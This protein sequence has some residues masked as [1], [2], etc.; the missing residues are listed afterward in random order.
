MIKIWDSNDGNADTEHENVYSHLIPMT[1]A[2]GTEKYVLEYL[3]WV[4]PTKKNVSCRKKEVHLQKKKERMK[5]NDWW[6]F[7]TYTK[8]KISEWQDK[9]TWSELLYDRGLR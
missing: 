5:S 7:S 4:L 9:I 1:T 2:T 8:E 3:W 6:A